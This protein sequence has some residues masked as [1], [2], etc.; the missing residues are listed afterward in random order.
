MHGAEHNASTVRL[1]KNIQQGIYTTEKATEIY[2]IHFTDMGM[3]KLW[4]EFSHTSEDMI[5]Q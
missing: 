4:D 3:T 1:T 5:S 2:F